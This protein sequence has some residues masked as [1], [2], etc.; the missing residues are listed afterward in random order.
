[1]NR[2]GG[3]KAP[4]REQTSRKGLKKKG[5]PHVITHSLIKK[6]TDRQEKRW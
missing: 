2:K 4:K 5:E 6:T 3:S 1:M